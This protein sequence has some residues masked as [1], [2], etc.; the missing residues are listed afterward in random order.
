M[1]GAIS[2]RRMRPPRQENYADSA[3]LHPSIVTVI[4]ST[5]PSSFGDA[6]LGAGPE[7]IIPAGAMDSGFVLR[8]PRNDE[9]GMTHTLILPDGQISVSP[10]Q[11]PSQK[12]SGSLLTQITSSSS[13][14]RPNTEGR[15]AIV[16]SVG[17]G[18]RWTRWRQ[19]RMV[20]FA[21]GEVVWS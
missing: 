8:T 2:R 13:P 14:S 18:M 15:F 9:D 3:G 11:S 4:P 10:V 16:T 12:Y 19:R 21:D 5:P 20:L 6:P 17:H 1:P 7:S